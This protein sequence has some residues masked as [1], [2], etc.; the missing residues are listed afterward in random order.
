MNA[1]RRFVRGIRGQLLL[2]FSL[3][4]ASIAG[5]VL[6]FFPMRQER[7]ARQ[8]MIAKAE[9]IRAMTAYSL[10]AGLLFGDTAAVQEVLAGAASATDVQFLVVRDEKGTIVATRG[11]NGSPLATEPPSGG[12]GV[13]ADGDTYVTSSAVLHSGRAVGRLTVGIS[14]ASLRQEVASEQ[15]M[16][17]MVAGLIFVIGSLLV[18]AISARVTR[19]LAAIADTV[20][21]IAGGDLSLRAVEPPDANVAELVHAFNSMVDGLVDAQSA[22]TTANQRLETRVEARTAELQDALREQRQAREALALSEADARST[23]EMLQTLVDLAPQTII[24]TDLEWRVTLWNKAA[25]KLFGWRAVEVLGRVGQTVPFEQQ[26]AFERWQRSIAEGPFVEAVETERVRKDGT[27]VPALV[28]AARLQDAN[29]R[30]VGFVTILTD[31]TDRNALEEQLRQSQKMQAIGSL[32][33]GVAHDFNNLLT[34]ITSC[35]ALLLQR[36]RDASETEDLESIRSAALRGAALTRQLLLFTRQQV[37]QIQPVSL[38][39]LIRAMLPMLKRLLRSNLELEVIARESLDVILADPSQIEQVILNLVINA[40]DAMPQGGKLIIE[41]KNI[42]VDEKAAFERPGSTPGRHVALTVSDTGIG[43]D[44]TV[45]SRVFEPFFTTKPVGSGTGLGLAT[46]YAVMTQVGGSIAV[47]SE[48]GRGSTF[49]LLFPHATRATAETA[50]AP[51]A[52]TKAAGLRE[53]VLLVEDEEMVR[54]IV[55]RGLERLNYKVLEAAD[56]KSALALVQRGEMPIGVVVTDIM[57][58]GMNGRELADTLQ[59][60][61]P[62]LP[63]VLVSGYAD[64]AARRDGMHT[65][66]QAFLQKPFSAEQLST[67]IRALID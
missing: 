23:S 5:F 51:S 65:G 47:S 6:V 13:T 61:N 54:R 58:P 66:M 35:V 56:A 2:S 57:M 17:L 41:T 8:G 19:P 46:T 22:L 9:T 45:M 12:G 20:R 18:Y 3:V 42:F 26:A 37:V 39:N 63:I 34:I 27:R 31:L 62:S 59:R 50:V 49:R 53:T 28:S 36:D 48:P 32:A 10:S 43:M 52:D 64:D 16:G 11:S 24:G 7:Q 60:T 4:V 67:T 21:R 15:R 29:Q 40:S 25:E 55:R 14:L 44:S 33:G 1:R 38:N 30:P